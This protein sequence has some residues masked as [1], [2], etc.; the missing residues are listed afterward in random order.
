MY[1]ILDGNDN[2]KST[3]KMH[4]AFIEFNEFCDTLFQKKILRHTA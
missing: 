2:E 3:N 1:S 4:H